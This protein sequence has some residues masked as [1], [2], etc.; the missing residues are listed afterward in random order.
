MRLHVDS[1]PLEQVE[2]LVK[3]YFY[4]GMGDKAIAAELKDH[5]DTDAYTC[6]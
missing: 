5:Y 2:D 3:F 6:R 1:V 4:L